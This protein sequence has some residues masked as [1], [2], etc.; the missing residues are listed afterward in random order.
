[1]HD[2]R[3]TQAQL[4]DL[5]CDE[6]PQ[7]ERVRVRAE[8]AACGACHAEYR[9]LAETLRAC[10]RAETMVQPPE[11]FW[12][13]YHARLSQHL[14]AHPVAPQTTTRT[15]VAGQRPTSLWWWRRALTASWR[16]PAPV[17]AVVALL[18][19][20]LSA[21]A[22]RPAPANIVLAAPPQVESA[23]PE[24]IV[25]VPVVQEKLVTRTI[26]VTR[27]DQAQS[28]RTPQV[29]RASGAQLAGTA[30]EQTVERSAAPLM[31]TGFQ[32]AGEVKLRVI[33]GNF[34]HE[35]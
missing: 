35:Q 34:T 11:D 8:T 2:C 18:L 16:V 28:R 23:A 21:L 14:Q 5:V 31:L 32:P 20:V 29:S 6:L 25:T 13:G 26:Y 33:K 1:M 7:A 10:V 3:R 30:Q 27:R 19:V 12:P 24:R 22:L 17:A 15:F 9:A 4:T